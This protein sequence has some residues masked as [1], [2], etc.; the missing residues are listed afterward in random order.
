MIELIREHWVMIS[1]FFAAFIWAIVRGEKVNVLD[2]QAIKLDSR[3]TKLESLPI[4]ISVPVCKENRQACQ[5]FRDSEAQAAKIFREAEAEHYKEDFKEL[6]L[7]L[8]R[9][10][11]RS[12]ELH[13]I[14]VNHLLK[15]A[16]NK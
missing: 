14:L 6:R 16:N 1:A 2:L 9:N 4:P 13:Q 15:V 10:A 12:E 3:V 8:S 11:E 5:F 7:Q